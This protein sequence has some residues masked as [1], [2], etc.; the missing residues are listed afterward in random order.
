MKVIFLDV[1]GVLNSE[2]DYMYHSGPKKGQYGRRGP[3]VGTYATGKYR[4]IDNTKVKRLARI[5]RETAAIIVLVSSWKRCYVHFLEKGRDVFG[6]YLYNKL[7]AQGLT[8]HS[9]TYKEEQIRDPLGTYSRYVRGTGIWHWLEDHEGEV[10]SWVALD[11]ETWDY[12]PKQVNNIVF[13]IDE[14]KPYGGLLDRQVEE[15]IKKLNG[16]DN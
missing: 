11:D 13:C 5:V 7:A 6:R 14:E 1:D 4:G 16:L 9:T 12:L 2:S 10:E 3:R 8:I 15:A